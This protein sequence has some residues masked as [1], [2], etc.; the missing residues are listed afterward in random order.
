MEG[1]AE[2]VM[3]PLLQD[4]LALDPRISTAHAAAVLVTCA[5]AGDSKQANTAIE[6][7]HRIISL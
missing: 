2:T 6:I 7:R 1:S 4:M 3:N 5:S